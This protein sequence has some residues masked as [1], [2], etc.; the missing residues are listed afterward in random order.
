MVSAFEGTCG[1]SLGGGGC[2]G[3]AAAARAAVVVGAAAA[4]TARTAA[5]AAAAAWTAWTAGAAAEGTAVGRERPRATATWAAGLRT[6]R[7]I[8]VPIEERVERVERCV[9]AAGWGSILRAR[10]GWMDGDGGR[11]GVVAMG[12]VGWV[13]GWLGGWVVGWM[14]GGW[15][16]GIDRWMD[17]EREEREREREP[18]LLAEQSGCTCHA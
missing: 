11:V 18:L 4:V 10:M 13:V 14:V 7:W 1:L 9:G 5:A 12:W 3:L 17:G 2:R 8:L 16:D 15:V 6:V